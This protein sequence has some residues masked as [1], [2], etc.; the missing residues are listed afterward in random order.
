[1]KRGGWRIGGSDLLH[2]VIY[3]L[4]NTIF[5]SS[6]CPWPEDTSK[7]DSSCVCA[8][9]LQNE[10]SI[11][12][13]A[14]N[15]ALL[16]MVLQQDS[17]L[18]LKLLHVKNTTISVL[19][20]NI[21]YGLTIENL[22]LSWCDIRSIS[23]GAFSGLEDTLA[24]LS[25]QD[26]RLEQVPTEALKNLRRLQLLDLSAN[27]LTLIPDNAFRGLRL[28][29]LKLADNDL[30]LTE[31]SL[32][33][34]EK[35]L[36]NLSLKRT[37]LSVLP[38][39]ILT[40]HTLAFLD[41]AHNQIRSLERG[42]LQELD[43]LA[44]LNLEKNQLSTLHPHD[45]LGINDTLTSLSLL[46]NHLEYFPRDAFNT[47]SQLKVLDI[48]FNMI[49]EVPVNAFSQV[50]SLRLL[51]LDGNPLTTLPAQAFT[52]LTSL[53]GLSLG[54]PFLNCDCR[55]FW[56]SQW[57]L[58]YDLQV[59]SRERNPQFCGQPP[60][61][62]NLSFYQ[63]NFNNL[64]CNSTYPLSSSSQ[65]VLPTAYLP[66]TELA[67]TTIPDS[68]FTP[69][70]Y[71]R[72]R[73]SATLQTQMTLFQSGSL[74]HL[75]AST[76][77]EELEIEGSVSS[78]KW[79]PGGQDLGIDKEPVLRLPLEVLPT[80]SQRRPSR[81]ERPLSQA[82]PSTV[83]R[84]SLILR[85]DDSSSLDNFSGQ[86]QGPYEDKVIVQEAYR[87]D[88][89]VI[90][91][92]N[93]EASSIQ[94]FRVVYRLFGDKNF[95]LG[96]PLAS[97]E[98]EF[99]I[100]KVPTQE[101]LVVCV[102]SLD[103][104]PLTADTVMPSQCREIRTTLTSATHMD[105]LII[106]ASAA[107]CGTVILAVMMFICCSRRQSVQQRKQ[108]IPA[109][110]N[111]S[112]PP[113]A[114]LG[115]LGSGINPD[116]DSVSMYSQRSI[117]RAKM[118]HMEKGCVNNR[119][120]PDD[121]RSHISQASLRRPSGS[122]SVTDCQSRRSYSALAGTPSHTHAHAHAFMP[123]FHLSSQDLSMSRQSLAAPQFGVG[124]LGSL[125]VNPSDYG[126]GASNSTTTGRFTR[127]T[128]YR[129]D[130]RRQRSKSRERTTSRHSHEGSSHS[131]TGYDTDGCTDHDMDI[132]IARNPTR[133]GLV[134]L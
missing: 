35:T 56:I 113:L 54:G 100:K 109:I 47:L 108:G 69:T 92:W 2:S 72:T 45:F 78:L 133:G 93:S 124:R 7:L 65:P 128:S 58:E 26:N 91:Q 16:M 20:D 122:Q 80:R 118:Y 43:S 81:L 67:P 82:V 28:S 29:I 87:K 99:K 61:Y 12:C 90:I 4:L 13:R 59:T 10:L 129:N 116:W 52:H 46:N 101:C 131:L 70:P 79:G 127:A 63:L 123:P 15:F 24:N 117:P 64:F 106:A 38:R 121:A 111:P 60:E 86:A 103:Q 8:F 95:K 132:Y 3:F 23:G 68:V 134:Q 17:S 51:A 5:V 75:A 97:S 85:N 50:K 130:R 125:P 102:V 98:R 76:P 22:Q 126:M 40:L 11:Q 19:T 66:T 89:S 83:S 119:M 112:S 120:V 9:N 55:L 32:S 77:E 41:L 57:I 96:P 6:Q 115:T 14:V 36:K 44:A 71:T 48:G 18:P 37:S 49:T 27:R 34:L 104:L 88:Q 114:S 21:F 39:S 62:R 31:Q 84:P 74:K 110:L 94:G 105:T 30:S 73:T 25:L 1:M 107:I 53:K 42:A 33:G